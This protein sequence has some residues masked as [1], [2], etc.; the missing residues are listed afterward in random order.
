MLGVIDVIDWSIVA[1]Q[2]RNLVPPASLPVTFSNASEKAERATN[3][4]YIA[5]GRI[6]IDFENQMQDSA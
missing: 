2:I 4:R 3:N 5:H 6:T 1:I